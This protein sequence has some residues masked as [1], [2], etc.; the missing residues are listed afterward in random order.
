MKKLG[1][2]KVLLVLLMGISMIPNTPKVMANQNQQPHIEDLSDRSKKQ[3]QQDFETY[4]S[5]NQ[6]QEKE[7]QGNYLEL[8]KVDG[9]S[10]R[11]KRSIRKDERQFIYL[12]DISYDPSSTN[13]W[14][15]FQK[16][17]NVEEGP[18]GLLMDHEVSYFPKG[19]GAHANS[20]LIY[21]ISKYKDEFTHLSTYIGI[22]YK[23]NSQSDGVEFIFFGSNSKDGKWNQIGERYT[24]LPTD[25]AKYVKIDIRDYD[26]ILLESKGRR[27]ITADHTVYGDLRLIKSDYDINTEKYQGIKTVSE[28]DKEISKHSVTENYEKNKMLVLKREFVNRIGY[29]TIQ[30][31]YKAKPKEVKETLDWLFSDLK[32]IQLF[33]EAGDYFSGNGKNALDALVSLYTTYKADMNEL[34]YKKMLLA[35]AAAYSKDLH[36]FLFNYGGQR[37]PSEPLKKYQYFKELY[38]QGDF[39]RKNEFK[40]YPMELVRA[41]MDAK[42]SNDEIHW[43]S[44]YIE[45]KY[46]YAQYA[47]HN[48]RYS[49]YGY[50]SYQR[51][52]WG[53]E[54][55]YDESKKEQW[56]KKYDFSKYGIDYGIK[57]KFRLWMLMEQGGICWGLS[58]LGMVVN[59]VQGIP[60]IGTYQ[61]GHEAY[62]LYKQNED[63][64]GVWSISDD[65]HG[66]KNS[67]TRWGGST[68]SEHRLPLEWGQKDYNKLDRG[69]N[70][71]YIILAQD[72]FNNYDQYLK[73]MYYVLISNSYQTTD[74]RKKE[75]L[76]QSL[77][78]YSKNLDALHGLYQIQENNPTTE[79][80]WM[81]LAERIAQEYRYFPAP[82][83]DL[84]SLIEPHFTSSDYQIR[85]MLL[86]NNTL[87]QASKTT[88]SQFIQA[89]VTRA[90]AN[91][92]LGKVDRTV[93]TFSFDGKNGGSIML[94]ERFQGNHVQWDYSLDGKK[95]WKVT[96]ESKA[97][98]SREELD[99]INAENDIYVHIMGSSYEDGNIYK[100][101]IQKSPN[102]TKVYSNDLENRLIGVNDTM[103][104]RYHDNDTWK[105]FFTHTPDLNGNKNVQVRVGKTST[106]LPSDPVT[107]RFTQDQ[108]QETKRYIPISNLS[109]HHVSSQQSESESGNNIIDGNPNTIWHSLHNGNDQEKEVVIK[110]KEPL[111]LSGLDYV[112][113]Q[114]GINGRIKNGKVYVSMDGTN[115]QEQST[116]TNW[117]NNGSTKNIQFQNSV[118]AQY[119]KL[120][121]T[122][123]YSTNG[124]SYISGAMIN[125]YEDVKTKYLNEVSIEY[126]TYSPT[127]SSVTAKLKLPP[128]YQIFSISEYEFR[129]NGYYTFFYRS[130]SGQILPVG[131]RVNWINK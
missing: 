51:P 112:P 12:S 57:G 65:I 120:K 64:K 36:I 131:A 45:K 125:L 118:R 58:G 59:E 37:I 13:G 107:Y 74:V 82:M 91:D 115:W 63:G 87:E 41:V 67:Y 110:L 26:Y 6:I 78:E 128:G 46:P 73:S 10:S 96:G 101:D 23:K 103:E 31:T 40:Q 20:K 4:A 88:D 77:T 61:P 43:L 126:S 62:L 76:E 95:T 117:A 54:D 98:L 8:S 108:Q 52:N 80:Q 109:V 50:A 129:S 105:K 30:N 102:P 94:G 89:S 124:K 28:Y 55:F 123:T 32:N 48:R 83:N 113:R 16:D 14:R 121:A 81:K 84:L 7:D 15:Q 2:S 29:H 75:A 60:A 49:G 47:N 34:V 22:N 18:I 24:L 66:W 127:T 130:P 99:R 3:M 33:I 86:R 39:V 97:V 53:R 38:D 104:W 17:K 68:H 27:N 72:A 44:D 35:T 25:E 114:T 116:F 11:K 21:D 70:T 100:I 71:S 9:K 93:A 119:V 85:L 5:Q 111:Y 1:L 106:Y 19:M 42:L 79:E 56:N 69:N 122:E 90:V 92:L